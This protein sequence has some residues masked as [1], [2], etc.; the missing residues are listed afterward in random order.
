MGGNTNICMSKRKLIVY[1]IA[2]IMLGLG[3]CAPRHLDEGHR[4]NYWKI[5]NANERKHDRYSYPD[6]NPD[7]PRYYR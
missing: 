2:V 5:R 7:R 1:G 3:S 4:N 6:H